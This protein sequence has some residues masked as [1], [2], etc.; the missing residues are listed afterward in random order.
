MKELKFKVTLPEK[1][2]DFNAIDS[3]IHTAN[4]EKRQAE[5]TCSINGAT[6]GL[7]IKVAENIKNE[8]VSQLARIGLEIDPPLE[9]YG[10]WRGYKIAYF[11]FGING[12]DDQYK[13]KVRGIIDKDFEH[14]K[15]NTY[16]GGYN[17]ELVTNGFV[18]DDGK[19]VVDVNDLIEELKIPLVEWYKKNRVKSGEE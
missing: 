10:N 14:S 16:T 13:V 17:I 1:S 9:A 8:L 3:I 18:W 7:H 19:I 15:Y 5:L 4:D 2:N 12:R 6:T 11:R